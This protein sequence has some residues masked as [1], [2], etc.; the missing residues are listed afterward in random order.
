MVSVIFL[1]ST[2]FFG[3]TEPL[4]NN[5]QVEITW[6]QCRWPLTACENSNLFDNVKV[7]FGPGF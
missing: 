3:E 5:S 2:F 4:R 6:T 1:I 7:L